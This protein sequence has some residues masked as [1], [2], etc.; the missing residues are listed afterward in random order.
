MNYDLEIGDKF[1]IDWNKI[2][3]IYS[4]VRKCKFPDLEFT[5]HSFS[6]SRLSVYFIDKRTNKKCSCN[7][8]DRA[9]PLCKNI[10]E[11]GTKSIGISDII[12]TQKRLS[13][14]RSLKL[15]SLGI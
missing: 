14:E 9:L 5:I 12:I 15:K 10:K 7:Y 4:G 2:T 3:K 1:T 11:E 8:C 6:K 13:V